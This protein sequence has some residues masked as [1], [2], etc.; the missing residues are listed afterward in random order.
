MQ[1]ADPWACP[2]QPQMRSILVVVTDILS[3]QPFQMPLVQDDDVIQQVSAT[4]SHPSLGDAVLP[5]TAKGSAHRLAAHAFAND[6]T[7]SPNF[8]SRSKIRNLCAG[9]YGHASRICWTI[10]QALGFLVT[11]Q[12]RIF[13]RSWPM[14]KKQY[15]TPKVSVGTV[16]K[17]IAAI[18]SR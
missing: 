7:S 1:S 18:A 2:C 14:T 16:K 15:R 12:R 5:R 8:E 10:H 11:F 13:R 17:S 4:A 9:E 3:N 6:T